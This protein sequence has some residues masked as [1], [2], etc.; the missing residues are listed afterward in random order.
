MAELATMPSWIFLT[1]ENPGMLDSR[2]ELDHYDTPLRILDN[3]PTVENE[4]RIAE[5]ETLLKECGAQ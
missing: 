3:L 1:K 5:V 4:G 2:G